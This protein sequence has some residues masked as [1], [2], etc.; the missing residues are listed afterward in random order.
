MNILENVEKMDNY[1]ISPPNDK[2]ALIDA[3][4]IAFNACRA[5]EYK[6][7][8]TETGEDEW[9]IDIQEAYDHAEGKINLIL[10]QTGCKSAELYFSASSRQTF[11][12]TQVSET[13]KAGRLK[14]RYPEG[15]LDLK[16]L[17]DENYEGEIGK[18]VEADDMVV[19]LYNPDKY[20]L[21]AI[22]KDVLNAVPGKHWNYYQRAAY[23][24]IIKG[25]EKTYDEI[26]A[27]FVEVTEAQ[28]KYWPY[29]QCIIGDTSDGIKGVPGLGAAKAGNFVHID[30]TELENWNGLVLAFESKGLS[31]IDAIMTMRLINMKQYN[32]E[33]KEVK[34]WT[35]EDIKL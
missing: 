11:R 16:L 9:H 19:T 27:K 7:Y 33:T 26:P 21:C 20:I 23:S 30:N 24:R 32:P 5:C 17:L 15:L 12:V 22:D 29:Y 6:F 8:N 14:T 10:E 13:Y 28:A 3:D 18:D 35:P 34:L 4:T 31:V 25:V 2:I 1:L